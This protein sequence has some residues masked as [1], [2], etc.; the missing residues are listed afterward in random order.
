MSA[1]SGLEKGRSSAGSC[2]SFPGLPEINSSDGKTGLHTDKPQTLTGKTVH[3]F[4]ETDFSGFTPELCAAGGRVRFRLG[5]R[6]SRGA[7]FLLGG[8]VG[9]TGW[10]AGL[11]HFT[12]F[13]GP[14]GLEG[15]SSESDP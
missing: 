10:W 3:I 9:G 14:V 11:R 7:A 13:C 12:G 4:V 6:L 15:D 2:P 5:V 1:S 8:P